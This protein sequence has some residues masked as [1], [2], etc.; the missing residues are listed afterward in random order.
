MDWHFFVDF[1][2]PLGEN[3]ELSPD[4]EKLLERVA[5]A[6][7]SVQNTQLLDMSAWQELVTALRHGRTLE[8]PDHALEERSGLRGQLMLDLISGTVEI[9]D[10]ISRALPNR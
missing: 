10:L 7:Q 5:N 4:A 8:I 6:S 1:N 9:Q 3:R 2:R